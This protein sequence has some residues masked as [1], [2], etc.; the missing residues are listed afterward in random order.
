MQERKACCHIFT[1]FANLKF[2]FAGFPP[3]FLDN[4]LVVNAAK[5]GWEGVKG[6]RAGKRW[7]FPRG[8][9]HFT[10]SWY[11][12]AESQLD[13]T[14]TCKQPIQGCGDACEKRSTVM[15]AT[16]EDA[17]RLL[18]ERRAKLAKLREE[19][20]VHDRDIT[21]M[22]PVTLVD[23]FHETFGAADQRHGGAAPTSDLA[24][25]LPADHKIFY[26]K[27]GSK[28]Q[29][30]ASLS[31]LDHNALVREA[32]QRNHHKSSLTQQDDLQLSPPADHRGTADLIGSA[33]EG[34][35]ATSLVEDLGY[36]SSASSPSESKGRHGC[37]G[38]G[39]RNRVI[40]MD[41]ESTKMPA[42]AATVNLS[43]SMPEGILKAV[44]T[45]LAQSLG[46]IAE[47]AKSRGIYDPIR[48][49]EGGSSTEV[50][51]MREEEEE[52]GRGDKT[53]RDYFQRMARLEGRVRE[54]VVGRSQSFQHFLHQS[55]SGVGGAKGEEA[56]R[57]R[58]RVEQLDTA[59]NAHMVS[60]GP[61]LRHQTLNV[62]FAGV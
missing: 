14:Y 61:I 32:S 46:A 31:D 26:A 9:L 59:D 12:A 55:F 44:K 49:F 33:A 29:P 28:G 58:S 3:H 48:L 50:T 57:R 7:A 17:G 37:A 53:E 6:G 5:H 39:P 27:D 36:Q 19:V 62:D 15:A 41:A 25:P 43:Q 52:G 1:K 35:L 47:K 13:L 40:D 18:A 8:P 22:P 21:S 30:P 45:D 60:H 54:S 20:S 4:T 2:F 24:A 56:R 42:A 11:G 51:V 16:T 38:G 23:E 34:G 10:A